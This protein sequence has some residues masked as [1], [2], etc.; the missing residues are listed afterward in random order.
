[1]EISLQSLEQ[2][3]DLKFVPTMGEKS[4]IGEKSPWNSL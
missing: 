4:T 1:M 3:L 2:I